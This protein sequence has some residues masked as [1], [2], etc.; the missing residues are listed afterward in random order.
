VKITRLRRAAQALTLVLVV[1][2]PLANSKGFSFVTGSLYS[3]EVGPIWITDPLIGLQ[4]LLTSFAMDG[5]LL[6]S[7]VIPAL[8]ALVFGRAFCGWVCPQN[9][10]SE[11]FDYVAKKKGVKRL[12]SPALGARPR[13][14]IL[15]AI[16]AATL[17]FGFPFAS[18]LSAPGIIS[19]QTARFI[20]EGVVGLELALIALILLAELFLVRRVW[21]NYICPVGSV[22]GLFRMKRT[23]K[24]V[25][26]EDSVRACAK[27]RECA[28]ACQLGLNP[29]G[30]ALYPLCHNCGACVG[31]CEKRTAKRKPLSF[32]F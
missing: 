25:F 31:A 15:A 5:A 21:C 26:A 9:T 17:V 13:Y 2:I 1:L 3:L 29:M 19:V 10:F 11:L 30:G 16:L 14:L 6:L 12:F 8:F 23:L 7:V 28:T 27:C 18:L 24:V 20:Y 4:T 22:L 32:E